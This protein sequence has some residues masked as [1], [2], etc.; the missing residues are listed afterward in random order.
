MIVYSFECGYLHI[1]TYLLNS[2]PLLLFFSV[3]DFEEAQ[4]FVGRVLYIQVDINR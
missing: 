4:R 1:C 2:L 3:S